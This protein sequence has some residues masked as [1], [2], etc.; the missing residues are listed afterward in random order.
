VANALGKGGLSQDLG[1]SNLG[2][3]TIRFIV[4]VGR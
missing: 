3:T 4:S 1:E 2:G